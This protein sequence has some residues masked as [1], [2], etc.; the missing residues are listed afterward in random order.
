V[1]H[2]RDQFA[3][4]LIGVVVIIEHAVLECDEVARRVRFYSNGLRKSRN[5]L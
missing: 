2:Q 1:G 5:L 3:R 4:V